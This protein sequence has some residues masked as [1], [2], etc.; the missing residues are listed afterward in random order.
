MLLVTLV[1]GIACLYCA[2]ASEASGYVQQDQ[3]EQLQQEFQRMQMET[4]RQIEELKLAISIP[5]SGKPRTFWYVFAR[6]YSKFHSSH[7]PPQN[8]ADQPKNFL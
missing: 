6:F 2:S 1:L 8:K 5:K 7:P 4:Q 3:F